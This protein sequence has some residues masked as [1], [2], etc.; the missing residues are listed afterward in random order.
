M[1]TQAIIDY[2]MERSQATSTLTPQDAQVWDNFRTKITGNYAFFRYNVR[3]GEGRLPN[4]PVTEQ[5]KQ[6][7]QALTQY[8]LDVAIVTQS[9]L[10][11]IELKPRAVPALNGQLLSYDAAIVGTP[12]DSPS[13]LLVGVCQYGDPAVEA[14][15]KD[16]D[17]FVAPLDNP[18]KLREVFGSLVHPGGLP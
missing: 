18:A 7:W 9:E 12:F 5:E 2:L 3:L 10:F 14:V 4:E 8:R 15:A 13:V 6:M 17:L 11:L 16:N 1:L